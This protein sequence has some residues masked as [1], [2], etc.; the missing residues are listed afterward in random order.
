M[1]STP[2]LK[3]ERRVKYVES[4]DFKHP[5]L[6]SKEIMRTL[7]TLHDVLARSLSRVFSSALRKKVDV[8]LRGIDQ[9]S[10]TDFVHQ[11]ESPSVIYILNIDELGGDMFVVFPSDFC[12]HLIERQSGGSGEEVSDKRT[13]T[14]IEEKIV[15]RVM[16]NIN[17]EIVIA[18]EPYMDFHI[19]SSMYESKPENIHMVSVDPTIIARF[20]IELGKQKV[21]FDISYPYSLLKKAMNNSI[22]KKSNQSKA[23]K[24]S[25]AEQEAYRQTLLKADVCIQP[26]LGRTKMTIRDIIELKEGDAIPLQ[27]RTDQPLNVN[28]NGVTKMTAFPGTL[29]GRRAIRIF[30]IVEEISEL[31]LL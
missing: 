6:F 8:H 15:S 17:Q 5:K 21:E 2:A 29:Q 20:S 11:I 18:W 25:E 26:L 27:Q 3:N 10:T 1:N 28:V 16:K 9:F 23:L 19:N 13:L 22:L 30:N 12:I 7:R 24:L 31:E 4:Y 14:T